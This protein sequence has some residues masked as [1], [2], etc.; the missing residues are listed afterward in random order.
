MINE[1]QRHFNLK[2]GLI[3]LK[4]IVVRKIKPIDFIQIIPDFNLHNSHILKESF[5]PIYFPLLEK[6]EHRPE[7]IDF[8]LVLFDK[9]VEVF[10]IL[11]YAF[12]IEFF[13]QIKHTFNLFIFLF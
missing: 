3:M 11:E 1:D 13:P 12:R 2:L 4:G 9:L 6:L 7:L 8:E 10:L 5:H